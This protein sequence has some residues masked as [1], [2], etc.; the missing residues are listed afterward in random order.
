M[1]D[2]QLVI[3]F[4]IDEDFLKIDASLEVTGP[5]NARQIKIKTNKPGFLA[6]PQRPKEELQGEINIQ[7]QGNLVQ[8]IEFNVLLN[9]AYSLKTIRG[10]LKRN[11]QNTFDGSLLFS[12]GESSDGMHISNFTT[13]ATFNFKDLA[14]TQDKK[15]KT[16]KP[17][18]INLRRL[19]HKSMI[20]EGLDT[21]M[22]GELVCSAEEMGCSYSLRDNAIL[23]MKNIQFDVK[24]QLVRFT[25][26]PSLTVLPAQKENIRLQLSSPYLQIEA[27]IKNVKLTGVAGEKSEDLSLDA[28]TMNLQITLAQK[29]SDTHFRILVQNANYLTSDLSMN[30]VNLLI[31]DYFDDTSKIQFSAYTIQTGSNLLKKPISLE[32]TNVGTQTAIQAQITDTNFV[33][34]A[35]GSFDP[36]KFSFAGRFAIP[37]FDLDDL[38]F[39]LSELS[40]VFPNN[41][42]DLKGLFAASGQLKINGISS[43]VGPFYTSLKDVSFNWDK[44]A[45]SGVNGVLGFQ[46][47]EPLITNNNQR[48]FVQNIQSFIPISNLLFQFYINNQ[49]LRLS[50]VSGQVAGQDVIM[51]SALIPLKT[52]N[53]SLPLR[54]A[55]N[56]N[57]SNLNT[58]FNLPGIIL[59][60]GSGSFNLPV[61]ITENGI[62]FGD[63][64]IKIS[65]GTWQKNKNQPDVLHL[66]GP[67]DMSYVVRSGQLIL[68]PQKQLQIDLDG[69]R[70]PSKAKDSFG[71][72]NIELSDTLLKMSPLQYV[73]SDIQ[74]LQS[75]FGM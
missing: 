62:G 3:P 23:N 61:T 42:S 58:Y 15:L 29:T 73:P 6:L 27:P 9:Y 50:S 43:I 60:N 54:T 65:N 51:S 55:E 69:W 63:L 32:V 68:T 44:T 24:G 31:N 56:I 71:P 30:R 22:T 49:S 34:N 52:P 18:R 39:N 66:F 21:I 35:Q 1:G 19:V 67:S 33:L 72:V 36:F 5:E 10:E 59:E 74:K 28:S 45:I 53:A 70:F 26:N 38:P 4:S 46:S 75:K 2:N 40:S 41:I 11:D 12:T 48:L 17:L 8:T 57:L 14:W 16:N 7:M 64:T 37:V 20:I 25:N 13:D 47:L